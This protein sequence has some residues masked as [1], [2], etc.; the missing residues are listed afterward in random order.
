M[1]LVME[2]L[3]R[4]E[5]IECSMI[6]ASGACY[7]KHTHE[8]YVISANLCGLERIWY[9]GKQQD[10]SPGEVT[11]Y[12]PMTVQASSYL[13]STSQFISLHLDGQHVR[14]IFGPLSS[15]HAM[16]CFVEG[17]IKDDGLFRAVVR[18][19]RQADS[20]Y[21]EEAQLVLFSELHRLRTTSATPCEPLR[22]QQLI[23]FMK[24]NL[25]EPIELEDLCADANL[26][27]FHLV[28]SFKA[29]KHLPPMQYFK[30]LRL[31]E[32]RR[33]LRLGEPPTRIAV[34]LGFFDQAHMSNAFRKVMGASPWYYSSMLGGTGLPMNSV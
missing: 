24:A 2:S 6:N 16:P 5:R 22:V 8:E 7:P 17:A 9:D 4:H 3:N 33:R 31:M 14:D 20:E 12:N 23:N 13:G 1:P 30:Q 10:V 11:L 19:F 32:V 29:Q 21:T 34:D 25:Y 15:G 26:S 28:R 27:K 18:L